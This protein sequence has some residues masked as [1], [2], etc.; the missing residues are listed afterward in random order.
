MKSTA[1]Y[2]IERFRAILKDIK[3]NVRK[4]RL[5]IILIVLTVGKHF[6]V[7]AHWKGISKKDVVDLSP[8][9][10][11]KTEF[12]LKNWESAYTKKDGRLKKSITSKKDMCLDQDLEILLVKVTAKKEFSINEEK[13]Q[14]SIYENNYH[15]F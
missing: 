4:K 13:K 14:F 3:K 15:I 8:Q 5:E 2:V 10:Q 1:R 12:K 9:R 6:L 11:L 7:L